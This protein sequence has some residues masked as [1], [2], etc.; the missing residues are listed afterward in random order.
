MRVRTGI[1]LATTVTALWSLALP[2]HAGGGGDIIGA[3]I[4]TVS[5][6]INRG[7]MLMDGYCEGGTANGSF[8]VVG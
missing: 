8:V 7:G 4:V 6:C 2:A 5:E 3:G 1:I